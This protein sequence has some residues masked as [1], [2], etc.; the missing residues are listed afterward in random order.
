M[1]R[2]TATPPKVTSTAPAGDWHHFGLSAHPAHVP[3]AQKY[4]GS[5]PNDIP[6][7]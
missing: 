6:A 7:R 1:A 4:T 2:H 3:A 5:P